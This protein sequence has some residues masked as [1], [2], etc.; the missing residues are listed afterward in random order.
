[1]IFNVKCHISAKLSLRT[2]LSLLL[3]WHHHQVRRSVQPLGCFLSTHVLLSFQLRKKETPVWVSDTLSLVQLFSFARPALLCLRFAIMCLLLAALPLIG[4][5]W[6]SYCK[7]NPN[8][9][10]S[11][12]L[13]WPTHPTKTTN[14]WQ[15]GMGLTGKAVGSITQQWHVLYNASALAYMLTPS[16]PLIPLIS[17]TCCIT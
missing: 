7:T 14:E 2:S 1:M 9:S 4:L 13:K 5:S 6:S 11:S 16:L 17:W 8:Q 12:W 15:S 10:H 3:H